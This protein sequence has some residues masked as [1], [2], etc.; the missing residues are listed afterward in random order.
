MSDARHDGLRAILKSLP[1]DFE[2]WG[3]RSRDRDYGPDCSC[4][5]RWF[6][7]LERGLRYDWGVCSNS[8]SPSCG[9]LTFEHQG[10]FAFEAADESDEPP[11]PPTRSASD[12]ESAE[13]ILLGHLRTRGAPLSELLE[14]C[15]GHWDFEDS[16]YRFYHQS[17]KVYGLQAQ[18][19]E[20]VRELS[21]LVPGR[22]LNAWFLA[23][24]EQ[25]TGRHFEAADNARW[26]ETTR[27]MVEAF[28]HARF[29]LEMAVRYAH[30]EQPPNPLPSGYAALL[31]L[32]DLR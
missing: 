28:F 9:L 4:G 11:A 25:G 10:C 24:V 13:R 7:P 22:R 6:V 14:R 29:F 30:L 8:Q 32:Y 2:P 1:S 3:R 26:T 31:Y 12:R 16:I 17:F 19:E 23:I 18:T 20:I 21:A 15:S 27:P 5:C